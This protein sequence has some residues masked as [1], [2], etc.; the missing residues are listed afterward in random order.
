MPRATHL[1]VFAYDIERD[2]TRAKV[3]ALLE[4][5]LVR[6]QK[7]IFEGRMTTHQAMR[8]AERIGGII[9][10]TNSLRVYALTAEGL[11]ASFARGG[12]PLGEKSDFL[13][14]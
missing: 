4:N 10:P 14:F 11:D 1:Y 8:L 13:L 5:D 6:V 9:A 12:A 7:S 2:G 3:A